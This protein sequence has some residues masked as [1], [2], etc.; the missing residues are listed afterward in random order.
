MS[1][2]VSRRRFVARLLSASAAAL[3]APAIVRRGHSAPAIL[4]AAR[5]LITNGI[6]SGDVSFDSAVVWSRTD[7]P[8]RM[9]VEW[10][11]TESFR[12]LRRVV[13]PATR[14]ENDFTA[15]IYLRRLP[16]GQRIFY[17]VR[18]EDRGRGTSEPVLGEFVTAARDQRDVLFAWS[19]DTCGQ[20]YGIDESRGGL[21]TYA[22]VRELRP[23]FF[24]H[25]GDT[26]YADGPLKPDVKVA[27]KV[28]WQNLLTDEKRKVA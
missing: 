15:K 20:G 23:D 22:A 12:D 3:G 10:S 5:P 8:A 21:R 14:E 7:R 9:V 16:P 18:F 4:E 28:V 13:G 24:I 6:A 19:G 25:S 26:I 1:H 2:V 17:R 27:E 11:T